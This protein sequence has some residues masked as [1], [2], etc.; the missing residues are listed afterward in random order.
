M[1]DL[2]IGEIL[3]L[4]LLLPVALRPFSR[5]LQRIGGIALFPLLAFLL[6]VATVAAVGLRLT[7][8]PV[9]ALSLIALFSGAGRLF[10]LFRGLPTDWYSP[11]LIVP[12]GFFA[13]LF[14]AAT[15]FTFYAAPETAYISRQAVSRTVESRRAFP[16]TDARVIVWAPSGEAT[17]KGSVVFLGDVSS[18]ADARSTLC[19][20]LSEGGYR[21]IAAD[22]SSTSAYRNPSL[23]SPF[24]RSWLALVSRVFPGI[25]FPASKGDI[26]EAQSKEL[27][28]LVD[29][30]RDGGAGLP[31]FA[32]AEGSGCAAL[33]RA[34]RGN[35]SLFD[36]AVLILGGEGPELAKD[37]PGGAAVIGEGTGMMPSDSG[38]FPFCVVTG[39]DPAYYGLGE[40]ASDDVLAAV[41]LG[42]ARDAGRK[43]AE[44]IARRV[45]SWIA[46]KGGDR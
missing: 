2:F 46:I 37:L 43:R 40:I 28:L 10:R 7:F 22:I 4:F 27:S 24:L 44:I 31:L 35:P 18:R 13:A 36:G 19:A 17:P 29:I 21:A 15:V 11:S 38:L 32:V 5:R 6:C 14:V 1:A 16:G 25:P 41:L 12:Y 9:F 30:A 3:I 42:G 39:A 8:I 33:I 23:H 26:L 45:S 20:A 34:L